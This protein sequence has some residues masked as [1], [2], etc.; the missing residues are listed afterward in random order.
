MGISSRHNTHLVREQVLP[1]ASIEEEAP[2]AEEDEEEEA[3]GPAPAPALGGLF[4]RAK[5][6]VKG[7]A[8]EAQELAD[9][10][11]Q[12]RRAERNPVW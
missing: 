9:E 5:A 7:A 4:G 12:V 1:A 2:E 6:A 3:A 10:A 8:D 11:P